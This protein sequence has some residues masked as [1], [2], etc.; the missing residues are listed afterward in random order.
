MINLLFMSSIYKTKEDADSY[1]KKVIDTLIVDGKVD[2]TLAHPKRENLCQSGGFRPVLKHQ[3]IA[4]LANNYDSEYFV[5]TGTYMGETA[6]G[7]SPLFKKCWT[8]E[9][10]EVHYD[11]SSYRLAPPLRTNITLFFGESQVEL[12]GVLDLVKGEG[13]SANKPNNIIFF[14]DAHYSG[15]EEK[16]TTFKSQS[17]PC[18]T[19][20]EL[21]VIRDSGISESIILVDDFSSFG[22][23]KDYPSSDDVLEV[24]K[25]IN[26][27]YQAVYIPE[28]D[29]LKVSLDSG[30]GGEL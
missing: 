10:S 27:N 13:P 30:I 24:V 28:I 23:S 12:P 8:I 5:E 15:G 25:Q 22:V 29:C 19:L 16:V 11:F 6:T 14:L 18:P 2:C 1:K 9:A 3:L 21:E 26:P 17:G 7:V 20:Q 4:I